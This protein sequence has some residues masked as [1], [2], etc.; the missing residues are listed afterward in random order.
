MPTPRPPTWGD[1]VKAKARKR[2]VGLL[3]YMR[4][5]DHEISPAD[6][7]DMIREDVRCGKKTA[8][9]AADFAFGEVTNQGDSGS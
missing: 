4:E 9:E 5:H 2:A 1:K 3:R 7:A 8:R 6:L